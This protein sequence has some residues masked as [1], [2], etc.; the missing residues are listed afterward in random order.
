MDVLFLEDHYDAAKLAVFLKDHGYS[1]DRAQNIIDA[2]DFLDTGKNYKAAIVDLD[3]SK[4]YLASE[5]KDY[6]KNQ[7]A[8]WVFYQHVLRKYPPLDENTIIVSA[9]LPTFKNN[10]PDEHYDDVY[11]IDKRDHDYLDQVL[12]KLEEIK[13]RLNPP[14]SR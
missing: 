6:A 7:F 9:L 12:A 13:Q 4:H 8:G 5:L 2:E 10:P 3:M 1:V 11:L 14:E